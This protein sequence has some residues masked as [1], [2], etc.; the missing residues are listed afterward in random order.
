[1]SRKLL[2]IFICFCFSF[3]FAQSGVNNPGVYSSEITVNDCFKNSKYIQGFKSDTIK[4][5]S[6]LR[7]Q[8]I[9]RTISLIHPQNKLLLNSSNSCEQIPLLEV[10]KFGLLE[11]NLNAFSSDDFA[12][13]SGSILNREYILKSLIINDSSLN[14]V[15]DL[16][17]NQRQEMNLV[18]RYIDGNDVTSYLLKEDWFFNSYTGKSEKR[19]IAIAPLIYNPKTESVLPLFWLYYPEWRG[20]L[21]A[22]SA[23][24]FYSYEQISFE[25]VFSKRYFI[26][27]IDKE[28]N[29]FDRRVS[30]T[31]HSNDAY[32]E[33]ELI[34]EKLGNLESDLFQY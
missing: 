1:M 2:S 4:P 19:I 6:V 5:N 8:K 3:C 22:F 9:W 13:T 17:G 24:N 31:N 15:F 16:E 23:K 33:S 29:V 10:I 18:K 27:Q 14:I 30:T 7:G 34:K 20:L 28:S 26:S 11:K 25:D 32:L 12:N 21:K